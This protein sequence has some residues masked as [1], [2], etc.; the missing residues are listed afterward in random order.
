M[1]SI[2]FICPV[3]D[4]SSSVNDDTLS[5]SPNIFIQLVL[6]LTLI[7]VLS[8][9]I[10]PFKFSIKIL[11]FD[12]QISLKSLLVTSVGSVKFLSILLL[13]LCNLFF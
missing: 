12:T 3:I 11:E 6:V 5:N 4:I 9:S 13:K 8:Y 1:N 7:I 10:T 2:D